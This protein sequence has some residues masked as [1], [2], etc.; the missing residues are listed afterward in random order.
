MKTRS[1]F[2]LT[3]YEWN[4]RNLGSE[5]LTLSI[6]RFVKYSLSA[7]VAIRC[8][9]YRDG[10]EIEGQTRQ[11]F[12]VN[13]DTPPGHYQCRATNRLGTALSNVT[14]IVKALQASFTQASFPHVYKATVCI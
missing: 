8:K 13:A 11:E 12:E 4:L 5:K 14:R 6:Q 10:R 1:L 9:W 3:V 2:R 7:F